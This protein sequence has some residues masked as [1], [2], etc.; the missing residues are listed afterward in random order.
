ML[1]GGLIQN[2]KN[3]VKLIINSIKSII[4]H[5]ESL[6]NQIESKFEE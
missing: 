4:P 5:I 3:Y 6:N 1:F 2:S